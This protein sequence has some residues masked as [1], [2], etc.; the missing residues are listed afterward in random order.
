[1]PHIIDHAD[2]FPVGMLV[3][4]T[5]PSRARSVRGNMETERMLT[6]IL[7][8]ERSIDHDYGRCRSGVRI[9]QRPA[10]HQSQPHGGEIIRADNALRG[11]HVQ[12]DIGIARRPHREGGKTT[13]RH[14]RQGR[15]VR[16]VR[17][18]RHHAQTFEQRIEQLTTPLGGIAW[19][20]QPRGEHVDGVVAAIRAD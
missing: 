16:R 14:E 4:E 12:L 5:N 3:G 2:H 15:A 20:R 10:G 13:E 8:S 18:A 9:G 19:K 1:M 11:L 7:A 17:D 6:K